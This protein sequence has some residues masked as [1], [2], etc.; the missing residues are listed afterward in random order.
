MKDCKQYQLESDSQQKEQ[1]I[2]G[3]DGVKVSGIQNPGLFLTILV[4]GQLV[5]S[6]VDTGATLTIISTRVWEAL[7]RS[8]S[9]IW[10]RILQ[11]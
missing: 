10:M 8:S 2:A 4:N 5:S 11:I 7:G 1:E 9:A 6:L 3:D